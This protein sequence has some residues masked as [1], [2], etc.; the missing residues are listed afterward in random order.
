MNPDSLD[1]KDGDL[2]HCPILPSKSKQ[3]RQFLIQSAELCGGSHLICRTKGV[4]WFWP[5]GL[6]NNRYRRLF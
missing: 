1:C 5:W 2:N 3:W 6:A 4:I